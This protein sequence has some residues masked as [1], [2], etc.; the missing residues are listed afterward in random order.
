MQGILKESSELHNLIKS[1]LERRYEDWA[2][3]LLAG[4]E[5]NYSRP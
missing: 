1:I 5:D 3:A 4:M 2:E